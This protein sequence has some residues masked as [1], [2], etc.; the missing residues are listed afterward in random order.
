MIDFKNIPFFRILIPFVLGI[1]L[2]INYAIDAPPIIVCICLLGIATFIFLVQYKKARLKQGLL[3][4]LDT[5]LFVLGLSI[6][7]QAQLSNHS[8]YFNKNEIRDTIFW[9]GKVN[10]IPV[11]KA[12]TVKLNL[13]VIQVK[14]DSAYQTCEG[15]VIVYVQNSNQNILFR[16]G[17]LLVLKSAF[18]EVQPAMNPHAF[19]YKLYLKNKSIYHTAYV[20]SNSFQII[21]APLDFSIWQLGLNIKYKIINRLKE[22]GLSTH[23]QTICTA[24]ITGFDDDIDRSVMDSFSHSGTMHVLSVSGLHVGLIYLV[25]NFF[26]GLIDRNKKYKLIQL[27]AISICLWFFALITGF[28]APVLRSVIMFN[29]LGFGNLFFRNKPKNQINIL[30]VSAFGLLFYDPW[31]IVDIGFLLSYSALFGILYFHPKFM[32]LY[33]PKH[34]AIKYVWESSL[35]SVSATITTLPIT[36]LYFHQ[37]PIWFVFA[38]LII[39]PATFILLMLAF[40]ALIKIPFITLLINK[41]TVFLIVF[42]ELFNSDQYAFIDYIDFTLIDAIFMSILLFLLIAGFTKRKYTSVLY[43]F[44]CLITW[45]VISIFLSYDSKSK[46]ELVVYHLN[47]ASTVS[48]KS[49]SYTILSKVDSNSFSMAV[50][51]NLVSYNHPKLKHQYFNYFKNNS[52]GFLVLDKKRHYPENQNLFLTHLLVNNNAVPSKEYL[53]NKKLKVLIADGSNS[54]YYLKKLEQLCSEL[55][56]HFYSTRSK[57]ANIM[58]F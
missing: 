22:V 42:I 33:T 29:L 53:Q 58:P 9:I 39:V 50:K 28:S 14:V 57:G 15:N 55:G 16:P 18:N 52:I 43:F 26:F 5:I 24:L 3:L 7:P 48:V 36:L 31:L 37:F 45:Q 41:I 1:L 35:V 2:S 47:R 17:N 4:V 56:I 44:I 23:A 25:L 32:A 21:N 12:K 30:F 19:D 20:D 54:Y 11:Q 51:P 6:T 27:I 10:D 46:S 8:S 40:I 49:K 34:K 38:N 13:K